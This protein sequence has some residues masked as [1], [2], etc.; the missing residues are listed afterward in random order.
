MDIED[1]EPSDLRIDVMRMA[2]GLP[3]AVRITHLPTQTVVM[4]DDQVSTEA[5]RDRAMELLRDALSS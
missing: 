3:C 5:N 1:I 4:A 2:D